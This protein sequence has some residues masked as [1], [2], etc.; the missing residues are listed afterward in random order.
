M[1]CVATQPGLGVH[2][3][4]PLLVVHDANDAQGSPSGVHFS[5]KARSFAVT[6]DKDNTARE[7]EGD[8]IIEPV[9]SGVQLA[10]CIFPRCLRAR[11]LSNHPTNPEKKSNATRHNSAQ[12]GTM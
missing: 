4:Y 8:R 11:E 1:P 2:C 7:S 12:L 10:R 9:L 6:S 3:E 5:Y